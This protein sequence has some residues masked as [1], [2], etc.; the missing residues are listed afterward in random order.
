[1]IKKRRDW[2]GGSREHVLAMAV[3][4]KEVFAVRGAEWKLTTDDLTVFNAL[5]AEAG[6]T[7]AM[8]T[9]ADRTP[10]AIP[11]CKA[12]F[13]ALKAKMR[14]IKRHNLIKPPLTDADLADLG[15]A[16]GDETITDQGDPEQP[17]VFTL[18][19]KDYCQVAATLRAEG[20]AR[21]AIPDWAN[22]AV[23]LLQIGGTRPTSPKLL[24]SIKLIT[25]A[26][27]TILFDPA[28]CGKTAYISFQWQ[29]GKG[30]KGPPA[31]IQEIT[32]P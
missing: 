8:L 6:N 31:P 1:M 16:L 20:T 3:N 30:E 11:K 32:I 5:I 28:D 22:G 12:A 27:Y 18:K 14:Y 13:K 26:H 25:R 7:L 24:P 29:N 2:I 23:M 17:P 9:S 10:S 4:W 21:I 15:L 19:S